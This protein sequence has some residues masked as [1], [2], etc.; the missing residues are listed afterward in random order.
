MKKQGLP[1]VIVRAVMSLYHGA[2]TK[3]QVRFELSQEFLVQVGVHQGSVLL[4]LLLPDPFPRMG[5][6]GRPWSPRSRIT[7]L[8]LDQRSYRDRE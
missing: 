4:M 3:V 6:G 5:H 8:G 2:K 1:E 7:L